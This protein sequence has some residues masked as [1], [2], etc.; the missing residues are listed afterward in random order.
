MAHRQDT[1]VPELENRCGGIVQAFFETL[2]P[3]EKELYKATRFAEQL[4]DEVKRADQIHKDKSISRR[5]SQALKPFLAGIDQYGKA[6]DVISNASSMV[7]CPIWGSIRIVLHLAAEFGEYFEKISSMLQQIGLHLNSLRRFPR[8]YPHN[9]RLETAMV[10]VYRVIFRFCTDARTVFKKVSDKKV[11]QKG[12][13]GLRSMVKLV[14]KPFKAQ[15]KDLQDE[16][17]TSM[18]KVSTEVEIAEKEEAHAERERADMERRAQASRWD[19]TQHTHQKLESFFDEQSIRKID[20]WL[21]PVNFESNHD[22]AV[23]LR[24]QG[25]GNWFLE[26]DAFKDWL[27]KDNAF[28]WLHAIPGAGK[29]VLVSSTIEFLKKHAKSE[30]VGLAYFYCDYK[31]LRK[32]EPSKLLCTLL[33]Q[34]ARQRKSVFQRL[35]AFVQERCKDNPA[36]VPIHDELRG[37][38]SNFLEGSFKQVILVV[39]AIDESTQRKCMIGDLKTFQKKC[40]FIKVLVSSREELDIAQAFKSFPHV[41]INQSDVAEDIESFVKAEVAA[42]IQEKELT[43]RRAELRQTICDKLVSRSEGMFQWVKC[44]IQVLCSLGTDKAILKALEQMPKDLAGTYA[45]IL[46]RLEHDSE[47]VERY[48]KLLRWLVKST[49][50]LTLDELAECIGID[51]DEDNESMDFDAVETYPENL[52]KRCSSLVTVNDDGYVSLAHYTVKEFLTSDTTRQDLATFYVGNDEVEAELAQTCLT[53]LCYNDFI[54]GSLADEDAL[55][56]V[57]DRYKFLKYAATAWGTHAHLSKGKEEDLLDLATKLLRSLSEGRGNY[58][59]WL[60]VYESSKAI[61]HSHMSDFKPLY[62]AA[63]FGLPGTLESLLGDEADMDI[64][65][66]AETDGDPVKEAVTQGHADV[67]KILIEHYGISDEAK[68]ANCLYIASSKGHHDIVRLL[69]DKGVDVDAVGGKQGTALQV[70]ALEGHKEVVQLLLARKAS[71]KVVSARFGT[72]LSA[73]AEKGHERGFQMLLN[74]GASIN[75]KGGWYAYP[76]ISAIVGQNDTIIQILLNKGANVNLTG[77]RH[78]CALMA[79]ATLGKLALVKK[80]IDMGAKVNDENDKGA[81]ALHSACCAG[82]LDVVELLLENGADVNAKGG[83]HRNALNAA[84]SEGYCQIVNVLLDA[85]ADS[86]AFDPNYGNAVQAAARAGHE[87]IVRRLSECGCDVNAM[88]GTRGTALVG[89]SSAGQARIVEVLFELGVPQGENRDTAN[90]LVA[91]V[92]KEHEDVVKVLVSKG[93]NLDRCGTLQTFPWLPLQLAAN[94]NQLE[95]LSILLG[96]GA[97]PNATG[98][99]LGSVLMG[100]A[101]STKIDCQIL[102]AQIVAGANINELVPSERRSTYP[103][104]WYGEST[105]LS[106]AASNKQPEAVRLLLNHDAD[107]NLQCSNYGTALQRAAGEGAVDIVEMLLSH[108]AGVNFDA[109]PCN[110]KSDN[111]VIT[112]LQCASA[113]ADE[114]TIRVLVANGASLFVERDDSDFKSALHAA[115]F[116][117]K[118]DNVK[119]L[120]ELGSEVNLRGGRYGSSLQAAAIGGHTETIAALLDAGAEVNEQDV[121]YYGSALIAAIVGS[122]HDAVR[123]L[124]ERGADPALRSVRAGLK[125]QYPIIAAARLWGNGEE[126][127]MLIDAGADVNARGGI[128]HTALQAAAVDG[129]DETMR[130]LVDAGAELNTSDGMYGNALSAAYREGYYFCT[131]LLWE[132]GVSNK[133][134][135]GRWGT[136][137]GSALSGA[138]QTLITFLIKEHNADPNEHMTPRYGS[139]LHYCIWHERSDADVLTNLFIDY[140]ADP[141]GI[142]PSGLGGYYGT[143]LNA[144]VITGEFQLMKTLLERGADPSIRGNREEWTS[145]QLACLYNKPDAFSLLLERGVDVNAHGRYGT[146]LQAAAYSGAKPLVREL[147]HR[148]ADIKVGGQ[149]RYGHSLQSAAIR[150]REDVVRFLIK[151]GA[152]VRIKGGRFGTILQAASVRCSRELVDFLI[153]KGAKVD[154]QGGRYKTALQAACA[155]G[156]KEVVL[157]LLE[158]KANVNITGGHYGSALQAAC[159]YGNLD[160]VRMLVEHGADVN[161]RGGF[162]D[163]A[164]DA[165]AINRRISI[166]RY[167][168]KE[169]GVAQTTASRRHNHAKTSRLERADSQMNNACGEGDSQPIT[170]ASDAEQQPAEGEA[171]EEATDEEV[172]MNI[173]S[174]PQ[175]DASTALPEDSTSASASPDPSAEVESNAT[176]S[177]SESPAPEALPRGKKARK[178]LA[179][180]ESNKVNVAEET[181]EVDA[182]TDENMAA[183][184]W[185]QVEC[186]YGGDLNGPGRSYDPDDSN[187]SRITPEYYSLLEAEDAMRQYR[188]VPLSRQSFAIRVLQLL[189][190]KSGSDFLTCKLHEY[191]LENADTTSHVY[192]TLSYAWGGEEKPKSIV[193]S[194]DDPNEESQ[195]P[196]SRLPITQSLHNALSRL[197]HPQF[198][199]FLWVDAVCIDQ[200]NGEEKEH[201]IQLMPAIYARARCVLVWLGEAQDDSDMVLESIRLAGERSGEQVFKTASGCPR[202]PPAVETEESWQM[203]TVQQLRASERT[204]ADL[205]DVRV[206][207][208]THK[209]QTSPRRT[210]HGI[211]WGTNVDHLRQA[212]QVLLNR[213]WFRRMWVTILCGSTE[214][215]GHVLS[216]GL[217]LM[218]QNLETPLSPVTVFM[219]RA[220][221]RP[222]QLSKIQARFSLDIG[223]LSELIDQYQANEAS[224]HHDKVYALLGMS[225]DNVSAA[226]LEPD[227]K[228]GWDVLMQRF[229][230]CLVGSQVSTHTAKDK[231]IAIIRGKCCVLGQVSS[232]N[233]TQDSKIEVNIMLNSSLENV[234][235]RHITWHLPFSAKPIK[236]GDILCLLQGAPK[237]SIIRSCKTHF[238]VVFIGAVPQG[239]SPMVLSACTPLA[240]SF[241]RNF[242]LIWNWEKSPEESQDSYAYDLIQAP[243]STGLMSRINVPTHVW[244]VA[245]ILGDAGQYEKAGELLGEAMKGYQVAL[246]ERDPHIAP[247]SQSGMTPLAFAATNGY[248]ELADLLLA[249]NGID[250]DLED[251]NGQKP[252]S[253]AAQHGHVTLVQRLLALGQ[254][255]IDAADKRGRTALLWASKNGHE[256]VIKQL[257]KTD[258]ANADLKDAEYGRTPLSWAAGNGHTAVVK[259]FLGTGLVD[260]NSKA[261][262]YGRTP[263]S[264]AAGNGH[265]AV[266]KLF[267]GTGLLDVN[268]KDAEYG[269]TPLSYAAG[270]GHTAVVKLFLGTGLVDVNSKDAESDRSF[271][272]MVTGYKDLAVDNLPWEYVNSGRKP[273]SSAGYSGHEPMVTSLIETK[274]VGIYPEGHRLG[275]TPLSWAAQNGHYGVVKLLLEAVQVDVDAVDTIHGRTSLSWASG[276]GH[277][278]VARLLLEAG[279]VAASTHVQDAYGQTALFWGAGAGHEAIVKLLLETSRLGIDLKTEALLQTGQV[280]VEAKD[281]EYSWTSLSWAATQ[282]YEAVVSLLLAVSHVNVEAKDKV[283]RTPLWHAVCFGHEA[284]AKSL[285]VKGKANPEVKDVYGRTPLLSAANN[286]HEAIVKLLLETGR[287]DIEA[288]D[289]EQRTP[290]ICAAEKGGESIVKL[291]LETGRVDIEAKGE[292]QRT[293]LS[294]AAGRGSESIVKLLIEMGQADV[295]AKDEVGWTPLAWAAAYGH[296][297]VVKTLIEVGHAD[298]NTEDILRDT[299]LSCATRMGHEAVAKILLDNGADAGPHDQWLDSTAQNEH[300]AIDW[301]DLFSKVGFS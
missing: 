79:A 141:N 256:D 132:R 92:A 151:H 102:E 47:N 94:R 64:S 265:T 263:L 257:L 69:L 152:D 39:D 267:L 120:L 276:N 185:L 155:A 103:S 272:P 56:D 255:E 262:E 148:G 211:E 135:G 274:E 109:E 157:T 165:A 288:K 222:R 87:D 85:G 212:T 171:D 159:A 134:R 284:V 233:T 181:K 249:E 156:N 20:Q 34:L 2:S 57:L 144:A 269:R 90:A 296:E 223:S 278:A 12:M 42:R 31:E 52:L 77:G 243:E 88:G 25:T 139:P 214:I 68:L 14:W 283:G 251:W 117:G 194:T 270:N 112:A 244:N 113:F 3:N 277:E 295:H 121:G 17:S 19:K 294:M 78:V 35:Q 23:K 289:D 195:R 173:E 179:R 63:S 62:F 168:V 252:L 266:V 37:N 26:G 191:P 204:V 182:E 200:M 115:S 279:A 292:F 44:Q 50:S 100:A 108:G 215:D 197:Q 247:E 143:P 142:G 125:Y 177:A 286:F 209:R 147:L 86:T 281:I 82:H 55:T 71:T 145:L 216:L 237:P 81:D 293:P 140:G 183:L 290:L 285:I 91:A 133:L 111:G 231:E 193:I 232:V 219:R 208:S 96:L 178:R 15:F 138:C 224:R 166:L 73:A 123:L 70:S 240:K 84:S 41:K 107:P 1:V 33:C 172:P 106:A 53:Y 60:Q 180:K 230:R 150:A 9:E 239:Q 229:L 248:T 199:R 190:S 54:A 40:P 18:D 287:V 260:V 98:G 48:Q 21:D 49:R 201:Q 176:S 16:L 253:H 192:E 43:I 250:P 122:N 186:G 110:E 104:N 36:A 46:Q 254:V 116:Y 206:D 95:M 298:V 13:I 242:L 153:H 225:S 4:L 245:L 93:A 5:V 158:Q 282:G 187:H 75:G 114:A 203:E 167:L 268:S 207:E 66:W 97:D 29:T 105:A 149:G 238:A 175:Y 301:E 137:L 226:G 184:S 264:W 89:A 124:L 297:A 51:L 174:I 129:N 72:P 234:K 6:L 259:L 59:F 258:S 189:P 74:A 83:K 170:L 280:D 7:L 261:A 80:L 119:V 30:D 10:D 8:L 65:T 291:L 218:S 236:Q 228:L 169:A 32:Q 61:H 58:E 299:P 246:G 67:V 118:T 163:S 154:A 235:G 271:H 130:V 45:R 300:Q 160:I 11:C 202:T 162:Y 136:P 227:Y 275:R 28:L 220:I 213:P 27:H 241:S 128:Y 131:G 217:G 273:L 188:Y 196:S 146:P 210:F 205:H 221:F 198:P 101:D 38:F 24:H 22:A 126:V 76:L 127:Q 164:A 99:F 161:F